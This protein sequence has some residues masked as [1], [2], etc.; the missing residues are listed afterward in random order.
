MHTL[1]DYD[2][3]LPEFENNTLCDTLRIKIFR[4]ILIFFHLLAFFSLKFPLI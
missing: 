3:L 4:T 2:S 1:L